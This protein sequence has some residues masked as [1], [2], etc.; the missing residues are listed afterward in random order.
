MQ[1]ESK[2]ASSSSSNGGQLRST[3]LLFMLD[4]ADDLQSASARWR[5]ERAERPALLCPAEDEGSKLSSCENPLVDS[6]RSASEDRVGSA[7]IVLS[8]SAFRICAV[9][10]HDVKSKD[11]N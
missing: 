9:C 8:L 11:W 1:E 3:T 2:M 7:A 4:R 10:A 5:A 6:A